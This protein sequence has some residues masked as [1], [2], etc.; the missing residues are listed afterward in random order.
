MIKNL[1][2]KK[3]SF[4]SPLLSHS[5]SEYEVN[6]WI[7]SDF[8]LNRLVPI[9]GLHPF[10]LNELMLM[11]STVCYFK[12]EFI[13]EWGTNIGKSARIFYEV[14]EAFQINT[15]IHSIDL[16]DDVF[17]GEHPKDNRGKMVRGISKVTLHQADGLQR[18]FEL[19]D[20]KK[21]KGRV[22]FFVDGDYSYE[23]V[24]RE[25]ESIL[26]K[27]PDA[28][29]LL[30]DTFYQSEASKYNVGPNKAIKDVLAARSEKYNVISTN[31]GL[32]GMT[33]VYK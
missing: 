1:F 24:K 32:P 29:V 12:P 17:H 4:E 8:I 6:N 28:A 19:I 16:P 13:F 25:L 3:R 11:T 14:S 10:P 2:G 26:V 23:S 33:L 18:S 20:Q 21:P 22:L 30:H 31:M 15:Q 27:A 5:G 7:V 9:V